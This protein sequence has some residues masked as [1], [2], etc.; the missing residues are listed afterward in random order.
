MK[1]PR[2]FVLLCPVLFALS[3]AAQDVGAPGMANVDLETPSG[4]RLAAEKA[5]MRKFFVLLYLSVM[6][7][8]MENQS[9]LCRER[10][11]YPLILA[12]FPGEELKACPQKLRQ[13]MKARVQALKDAAEGRKELK[14]GPFNPEDPEVL[15][16]LAEYGM[17]DMCQQAM[18]W[19]G[20]EVNAR[21]NMDQED[22]V[23]AFRQ[24]RDRV[25]SGNLVMPEEME[26]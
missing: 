3:G 5:S 25:R 22:F 8:A 4:Q 21:G 20:R 2:M 1:A 12:A 10:D 26:E 13:L 17:E 24:F 18:A 11:L 6:L 19:I 23:Q 9:D 16:F 7:P 15:A 14:G